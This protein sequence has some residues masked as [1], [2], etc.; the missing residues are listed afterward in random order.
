MVEVDS[1]Q[2]TIMQL[3]IQTATVAVM[4]QTEADTGANMANVGE[5]HRHRHG[6]SFLRHPAFN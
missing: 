6:R 5:V 1:M 4:V 3:A 2:T